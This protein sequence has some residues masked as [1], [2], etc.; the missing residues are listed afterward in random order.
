MNEG[1]LYNIESGDETP[2][3][4]EIG[5]DNWK[6]EIRKQLMKHLAGKSAEE[7]DTIIRSTLGNLLNDSK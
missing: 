2:P 7:I 5:I 4:S 6:H 3:R 1:N